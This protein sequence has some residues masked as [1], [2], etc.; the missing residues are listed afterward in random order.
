MATGVLLPSHVVPLHYFLRYDLIDL[1]TFDFEGEVS[2]DLDVKE[3]TQNI[4]LHAVKLWIK[5]A[6]VLVNQKSIESHA[7][8]MDVKNQT[9]SFGFEQAFGPGPCT[10]SIHFSGKLNSHLAGLYRSSYTVDNETRYM[11]VTQFEATDA[12]LAFP[13]F[14]EP[15]LKATYQ[16]EVAAAADRTVISNTPIELCTERKSSRYRSG[17]EKLWRFAKTPK[18]STYLLALIIGEF[19][20][21]SAFSERNRVC[22]NIFTPLGKAN[23]GQFALNV[24]TK[25]LDIYTDVFGIPYPLAKMDLLAIP[26]LAAGAMENWGCITY[27]ETRILVEEGRTTASNKRATARTICHEIA[28]QWFGN[29]ST[30]QW[31]THLWLNE[32][33]AR[34]M[35]FIAVDR[36]FPEWSIWNEFVDRI[37]GSALELDGLSSSHP[38]EVEV[39]HPD[40]ISSIFDTISYGKGASIIRMLAAFVGMD[41]FFKALHMYLTKYSYANAVTEDL[42]DAIT[43]ASGKPVRELMQAWTGRMGYPL[44]NF[45][46]GEDGN[47][48]CV[49]TRY[50]NSKVD[51]TPLTGESAWPVPVVVQMGAL[52]NVVQRFIYKGEPSN[53]VQTLCQQFLSAQNSNQAFKLDPGCSGFYRV[54]YGPVLWSAVLQQLSLGPEKSA[55]AIVDWIGILDDSF[56]LGASGHA[57]VTNALEATLAVAKCGS[58]A[59]R[60]AWAVMHG[61][62]VMLAALY[63][64]EPFFH[65]F[66]ALMQKIYLPLLGELGWQDDVSV[67]E[68]QGMS[69]EDRSE[70]RRMAVSG[71]ITAGHSDTIDAALDWFTLFVK[72]PT[73]SELSTEMRAPI[74]RAAMENVGD[75]AFEDLKAVFTRP[76]LLAEE[77]VMILNAMGRGTTEKL[78]TQA[79]EFGLSNAVR[80]QDVHHVFGSVGSNPVTRHVAWRFLTHR[81]KDISDKVQGAGFIWANVVSGVTGGFTDVG[82]ADEIEKFFADAAHPVGSGE[83]KLRQALESIRANAARLQRDRAIIPDW[84]NA[85]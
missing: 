46:Q 52:N 13:C 74:L 9:V 42:W 69:S 1:D 72:N 51:E 6:S 8:S 35:E 66:Q 22:V 55:Y 5:Q 2:I 33:F 71:L 82:M 21:I 24:A 84:L 76:E 26:D 23:Q 39:H 57:P 83:R 17:K 63:Y 47:L 18:M 79:L 11:A 25:A 77:R 29:L 59:G 15:A 37:R 49:Q 30:M 36:I 68:G 19:D 4:T 41:D 48:T 60:Q 85:H 54:N 78:A 3:S 20:V 10:L 7:I 32:G 65:K 14:D 27:R 67:Q 12:R 28:H 75:S 81:F 56:A 62:L 73:K 16:I 40:E 31:W 45:V 80:S 70:L 44:L 38:V 43:T 61:G 58:R 34:Y 50:W 64:N 53:D